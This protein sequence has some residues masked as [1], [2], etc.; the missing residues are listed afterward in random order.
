EGLTRERDA[1]LERFPDWKD[2]APDP[3]VFESEARSKTA[4][5]AGA[6]RLAEEAKS[7]AE[8]RYRKIERDLDR[9]RQQVDSLE[10]NRKSLEE[11]LARR[12]A[13][14]KPESERH[15]ELRAL[16]LSWDS[17]RGRVE[18]FKKQLADLGD[19]PVEALRRAR[20][21]GRGRGE[22]LRQSETDFAS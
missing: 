7:S 9:E 10:E 12:E 17:A 21:E 16:A 11:K 5:A 6:L 15:S 14:G 13:D 22:E 2:A 4:G 3:E 8:E 19:D 20:E 18:E 1:I